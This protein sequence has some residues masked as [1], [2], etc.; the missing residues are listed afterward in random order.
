V[1]IEQPASST[2]VSCLVRVVY[3]RSVR[4]LP[5]RRSSDLGGLSLTPDPAYAHNVDA[6]TATASYTFTGDANHN[7]SN[8]SKDFTIEKA[9]SSTVVSC[10]VSVVYDRKSRRLNSSQVASAYAVSLSQ[11][12]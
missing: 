3:Y 9:D 6:G 2:L 12:Q 4:S 11:D 5:T 8:G 7:G 10:P 1:T